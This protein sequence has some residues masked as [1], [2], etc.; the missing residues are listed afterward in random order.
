M[1][2]LTAD[3]ILTYKMIFGLLD[4]R[5]EDYFQPQSTKD[6]RTITRYNPYKLF[7]NYCQTNV[8]KKFLSQTCCKSLE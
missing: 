8:R 1:W 2:R 7:V 6:D 4:I 5:M 3:R